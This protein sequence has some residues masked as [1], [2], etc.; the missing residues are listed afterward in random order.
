[1]EVFRGAIW[2]K[3]IVGFTA[4]GCIGG[5][6][7]GLILGLHADSRTAGI[8][9][10]EGG[11]FGTVAGVILGALVGSLIELA[12]RLVRRVRA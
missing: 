10:L 4:V 1:M 2:E 8:A 3:C 12:R 5:A 6:I 9:V 7:T 11:F